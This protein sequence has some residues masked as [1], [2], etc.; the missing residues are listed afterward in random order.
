MQLKI[1][2]IPITHGDEVE[3]EFNRFLRSHKI[4]EV[5]QQ[6]VVLDRSAYWT[7]AVSYT[8]D[9]VV[10]DQTRFRVG[11]YSCVGFVPYTQTSPFRVYLPTAANKSPSAAEKSARVD[12]KKVLDAAS[13]ERFNTYR[14]IRKKVAQAEGI[15]VYTIFT[16]HELAEMA[17]ISRPITLDDLK[18][19]PG[20]GHRKV[21][22]YASYFTE[23]ETSK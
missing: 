23:H 4:L 5:D 6:I 22:K 2:T 10:W 14:N 19:I 8:D 13:F 20:I 18:K 21:E 15:P 7:F 16:N 3:E 11:I 12:Y 9:E 1:F 17:K